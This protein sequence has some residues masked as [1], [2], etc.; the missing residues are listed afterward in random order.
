MTRQRATFTYKGRVVY[1]T[2]NPVIVYGTKVLAYVLITLALPFSAVAWV[3]A[4]VREAF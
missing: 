2:Y 4:R 3:V 1:R